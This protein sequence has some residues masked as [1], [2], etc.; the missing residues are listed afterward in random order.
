MAAEMRS[1]FDGM[2]R[3]FQPLDRFQMAFEPS[4]AVA[5][6][7]AAAP[8]GASRSEQVSQII[9]GHNGDYDVKEKITK[10]KGDECITHEVHAKPKKHQR[11]SK[12]T[13]GEDESEVA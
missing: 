5:N 11:A 12:E 9:T 7:N 8:P 6:V 2:D 3:M 4:G 10:C 1:A 13:E